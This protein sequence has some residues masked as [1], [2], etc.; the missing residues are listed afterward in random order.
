ME[1]ADLYVL[2]T[3][4]SKGNI[5]SYPQGGGSSTKPRIKAHDNLDSAKRSRRYNSG[6]IIKVTDVEIVE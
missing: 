4:D 1:I 2:A 5:V 6:T 3:V